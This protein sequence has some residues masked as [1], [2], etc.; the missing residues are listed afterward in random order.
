M[1]YLIQRKQTLFRDFILSLDVTGQFSG[2]SFVNHSNGS[3]D[4]FRQTNKETNNQTNKQQQKR[5]KAK[6]KLKKMKN[7]IYVQNKTCSYPF[8]LL[9]LGLPNLLGN[10]HKTNI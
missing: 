6:K 1:K 10:S 3:F 5:K 7:E 4:A 8:G 2:K 9:D